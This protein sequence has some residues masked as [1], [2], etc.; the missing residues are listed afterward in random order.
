METSDKKPVR[1]Q[2]HSRKV[3]TDLHIWDV[4]RLMRAARWLEV[5][6][7]SPDAIAEAD[8]NWWYGAADAIP[9]PRSIAGHLSL[10]GDLDPRH[11]I[12]LC[13]DGRLM[14]GMHRV[15]KAIA[16]GRTQIPA[17]RFAKTPPPDFVN[18]PLDSLPYDDETI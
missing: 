17:V 14:D 9:T 4:H 2:Y 1:K 13:A 16:E 7:V 15:V 3:G 5:Q 10:I 11:P 6:M 12:I 18:R 8:E